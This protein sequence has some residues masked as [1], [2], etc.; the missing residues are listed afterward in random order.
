MPGTGYAILSAISFGFFH[1]FNRRGSQHIDILWS[2]YY[3]LLVSALILTTGVLI[4]S[5]KDTS[6]ILPLDSIGH[7][8][9]ASIF[10]SL[11]GWTLVGISQR[12]IGASNTGALAGTSP[13]FGLILAGIL[14]GEIPTLQALIGIG[15]VIAGVLMILFNNRIKTTTTKSNFI[16]IIQDTPTILPGLSAAL[17]WS[18]SALFVRKALISTPF[19]LH[20]LIYGIYLTIFALTI[21]LFLRGKGYEW[22][23]RTSNS[24]ICQ[25]IAG[26][27]VGLGLWSLWIAID[28][29]QI[30]VV[31]ALGRLNIPTILI[32]APII[33]GGVT[34]RSSR[35]AWL[36]AFLII[37]GSLLIIL[38]SG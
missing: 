6:L 25:I 19:L 1:L 22:R 32:F 27:F 8:G 35:Q 5:N 10:Q 12:K 3:L 37:V 29:T 33:L 15:I 20:G 11:F 28:K 38:F 24:L 9:L 36:S 14:F 4:G 34:E 30:A 13:L 2:T 31:L 26:I 23:F 17:C 21:V 16:K 18:I 7:F